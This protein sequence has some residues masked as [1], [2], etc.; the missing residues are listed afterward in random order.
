MDANETW[1]TRFDK[2]P[3][4]YG[5]I[6]DVAVTSVLDIKAEYVDYGGYDMKFGNYADD[7]PTFSNKKMVRPVFEV[8]I[9]S[10]HAKNLACHSC[11]VDAPAMATDSALVHM[12]TEFIV[13]QWGP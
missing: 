2:H 13:R 7:E 6:L 11:W 3:D 1:K 12:I 5:V 4:S 10:T 8:E 9:E